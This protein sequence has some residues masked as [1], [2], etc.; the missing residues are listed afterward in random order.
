MVYDT[1]K[2]IATCVCD[3]PN[4]LPAGDVCIESQASQRI[5]NTYSI[6]TII[7]HNYNHF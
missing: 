5:T 6:N 2:A 3:T 4:Y 1:S 7:G